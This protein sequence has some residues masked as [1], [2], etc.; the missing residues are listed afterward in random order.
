MKI[1]IY[2]KEVMEYFNFNSD[3]LETDLINGRVNAVDN[4]N[5]YKLKQAIN[6]ATEYQTNIISRNLN[7]TGVSK[8]FFSMEN[9]N[10]LQ[11]GIRN[12][13]LNDTNGEY[14]IGRQKDDELKIVMRSIYFQHAK[15]QSTNI[16]QQ[17]L[18][19][20]TKVIEWCVPEIISN[21]KQSQQ[22][23]KDISTMPVP[24]E[25]SVMPS[26]KGLKTLDVTNI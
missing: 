13:I 11:T 26:R 21:I 19:L 25:R 5:D 18:E 14:N 22:Y 1:I 2:N 15:N 12:K 9:I 23:I 8:I 20:N 3:N 17:V 10:L 16:P 4:N 7:C 24:L 6:K